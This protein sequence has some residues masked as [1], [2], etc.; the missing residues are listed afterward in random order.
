MPLMNAGEIC[1]DGGAGDG[2][3]R[4]FGGGGPGG[5]GGRVPI[6]YRVAR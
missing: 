3:G 2:G 1:T 6:W 4:G 5:L